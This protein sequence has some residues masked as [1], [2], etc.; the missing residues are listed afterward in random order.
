VELYFFIENI[1]GDKCPQ[2]I[3]EDFESVSLIYSK[4]AKA[5]SD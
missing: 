2:F 5:I 1:L 3:P 4:I